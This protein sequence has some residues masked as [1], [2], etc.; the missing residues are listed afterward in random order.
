VFG[1]YDEAVTDALSI[2][3]LRFAYDEAFR[4]HV[5]SFTV[6]RG[7]H[8]LLQ[9]AS[10]CGKSTLLHCIAGLVAIESGS[11]V[12]TGE[13]MSSVRG[14]AQDERRGRLVGM[15]FQTHHLL[16]GFSARENVELAMLFSSIEPSCHHDRAE[17]LLE[18][19]ELPSIDRPIETLSVGQQQRVAL[20]R[21][22]AGK[23]PLLLADEPTASL[24]PPTANAAMQMLLELAEEEGATVLLSTHDPSHHDRFER[25]VQFEDIL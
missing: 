15:V 18:R 24:D 10:G 2:T 25:I 7:E 17:S 12:V 5:P 19:L 23:P 1:Q 14:A 16:V 8:V 11:I 9:G 20:A 3:N 4:L 21:A 13:S 6:K 22:V